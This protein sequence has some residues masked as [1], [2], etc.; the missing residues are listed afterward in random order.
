MINTESFEKP[1]ENLTAQLIGWY[2]GIISHLPNISLSIIITVFA[3][4][5][6][7]YIK[8][9]A[10]RFLKRFVSDQSILNLIANIAAGVFSIAALFVVLG[11]LNLDKALN[12]F[13]AT[14]G[15]AGLAIGLALQEPLTNIFSGVLISVRKMY[16]IGDLI[17]TNNF[18]GTISNI[19]LK[20]TTVKL[21]TGENVYIPNKQ[22]LQNPIKNYSVGRVRRVDIEVGISYGDDLD[23]VENLVKDVLENLTAVRESKP[24]EVFFTEFGAS[25]INMVG[26]FW[27]S[28]TDQGSYLKA[29][30]NAIVSIRKSFEAHDISIPFPIR[31]LDFGVRETEKLDR[32]FQTEQI[33]ALISLTNESD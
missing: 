16:N 14:A 21:L 19:S 4:F 28:N 25:S 9:G 18:F 22:V 26:R 27:I 23:K 30:S 32:Q 13:L 10:K 29:K 8:G 6:V 12:T 33:R 11:V 31:T 3:Y 15:V 5:G 24:V 2:N 20:A 7:R 1:I 17:E